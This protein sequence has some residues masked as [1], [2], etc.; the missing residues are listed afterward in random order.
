MRLCVANGVPALITKWIRHR[1]SIKLHRAQ[2]TLY[3]EC[4]PFALG[5]KIK[6]N[7]FKLKIIFQRL[8]ISCH[9]TFRMHCTRSKRV[10]A[11]K[12]NLPPYVHIYIYRSFWFSVARSYSLDK[13]KFQ[14]IIYWKFCLRWRLCN[15]PIIDIMLSSVSHI[16]FRVVF[17]S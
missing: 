16:L 5:I 10:N 11:K 7:H 14:F 17:Y 9:A 15:F 6:H 3:L 1:F 8:H 4:I 12:K 2:S 13:F